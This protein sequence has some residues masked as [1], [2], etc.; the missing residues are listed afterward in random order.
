LAGSDGA[1]GGDEDDRAGD[2]SADD[3]VLAGFGAGRDLVG[4]GRDG[5]GRAEAGRDS[6]AGLVGRG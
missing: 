1:G 4:A 6:S 3:G 5:V 2:G